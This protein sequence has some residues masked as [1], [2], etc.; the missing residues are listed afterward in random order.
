MANLLCVLAFIVLLIYS[1]FIQS[2]FFYFHFI[3][4]SFIK[5]PSNKKLFFLLQST[6]GG[7]KLAHATVLPS[8]LFCCVTEIDSKACSNIKLSSSGQVIAKVAE[9]LTLNFMSQLTENVIRTFI[10]YSTASKKSRLK[11]RRNNL[12]AMF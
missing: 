4:L 2:S 9:F 5:E 3:H 10:M 7:K 1:F 11:H 12:H 6:A 8:L